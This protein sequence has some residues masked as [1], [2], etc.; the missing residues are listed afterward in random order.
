MFVTSTLNPD[1]RVN[2]DG[3]SS[4]LPIC[5]VEDGTNHLAQK[6]IIPFLSTEL[7]IQEWQEMAATLALPGKAFLNELGVVI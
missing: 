5:N 1:K 3:H 4:L 7:A 2:R 6:V